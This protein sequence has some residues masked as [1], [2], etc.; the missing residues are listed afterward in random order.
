MTEEND[1][2]ALSPCPF[3][4]GTATIQD[5]S[6]PIIIKCGGCKVRVGWFFQEDK[7][8]ELWNSR[9]SSALGNRRAK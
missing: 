9:I 5:T 3:C 7:A 2:R 4:G 1:G 8:R 6:Q